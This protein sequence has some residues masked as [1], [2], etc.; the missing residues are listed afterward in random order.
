M[1]IDLSLEATSEMRAKSYAN[2]RAALFVGD[3]RICVTREQ[4]DALARAI[5]ALPQPLP[6]LIP[7]EGRR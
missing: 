4:A 7:A 1:E 6:V 3:V 2:G 5:Q